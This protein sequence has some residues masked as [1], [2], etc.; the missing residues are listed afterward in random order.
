MLG[1]PPTLYVEVREARRYNNIQRHIIHTLYGL[2]DTSEQRA[3]ERALLRLQNFGI[4]VV[5]TGD[6]KLGAKEKRPLGDNA[7]QVAVTPVAL[8]SCKA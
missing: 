2:P 3:H 8:F 6:G 1:K 7:L 4:Q 5:F